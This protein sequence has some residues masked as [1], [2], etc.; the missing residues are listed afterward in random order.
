MSNSAGL[1]MEIMRSKG[2]LAL[3]GEERRT[4]FQGVQELYDLTPTTVWG[5]SEE[6][7]CRIL[8]VGKNLDEPLLKR[9]FL[10][11]AKP[12]K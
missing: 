8:L 10:E 11:E 12:G 1:Q 9:T 4:V 5:P 6:R 7:S 2:V 3:V